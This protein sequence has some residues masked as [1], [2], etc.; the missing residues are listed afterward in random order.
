MYLL[1]FIFQGMLSEQHNPNR[2]LLQAV[3][4]DYSLI[5]SNIPWKDDDADG[6]RV[7]R[8]VFIGK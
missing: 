4:E 1:F 5:D 7:N 2:L 6:G 3:H 8:L